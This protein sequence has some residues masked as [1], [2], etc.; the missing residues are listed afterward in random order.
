MTVTKTEYLDLREDP[1]KGITIAGVRMQKVENTKEIMNILFEG[2]RRRTTES[3]NANL[4][5][6]RSHA[7]FQIFL[8]IQ[9]KKKGTKIT[10]LESK[11]SLIDLAGSERGT[12]T[13]N[14]GIRLKEGAKINRSLLALANCINALGDQNKKGM[15]IP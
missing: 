15:F 9:D 7:I 13:E 4:T 10:A 6:S 5:S 11:L 3:T 12:V 14:R 8:R 1:D 2:N